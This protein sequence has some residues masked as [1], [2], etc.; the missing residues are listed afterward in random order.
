MLADGAVLRALERVSGRS[1]SAPI[2]VLAET[3]STNDDAKALA[4]EG[5]PQATLVV[6]DAQT[7]GRG[8]SGARWHSPA[9]EN[10]YLSLVLRPSIAAAAVAPF[11]LV[12]GLVVAGAVDE[13]TSRAALVKWPNDVHVDGKKVSGILVE[14]Q[15]RGDTLSSIVVGLGVNVTTTSFP[16]PLDMTATSLA[17]LGARDR[18]RASLAAAIAVGLVDA[19]ERFAREGLAPFARELA[20]RDALIGRRVRVGDVEGLAMGIDAEGRLLVSTDADG[21]TPI[22]AG[23]VELVG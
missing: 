23:H 20:A 8:R 10:L 2:R 6:A 13:R 1:W 19:V 9:G 22:V 16:P 12:A 18:D 15:V 4:R 14:G 17:M 7:A 5:A 3:G 11:T 21:T